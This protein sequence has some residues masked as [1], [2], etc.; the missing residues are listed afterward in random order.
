MQP[1]TAPRTQPFADYH[2]DYLAPDLGKFT[3]GRGI[4]LRCEP[5]RVS[6]S[7]EPTSP[8]LC[9][10][11]SISVDSSCV[12]CDNSFDHNHVIATTSAFGIDVRYLDDIGP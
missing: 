2:L 1:R 5:S 6:R 7:L 9:P 10:L 12:A 11:P 8:E 3:E 4:E